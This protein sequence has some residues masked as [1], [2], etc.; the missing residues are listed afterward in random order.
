M[1]TNLSIADRRWFVGLCA[2]IVYTEFTPRCSDRTAIPFCLS[3]AP[4][5]KVI[6]QGDGDYVACLGSPRPPYLLCAPDFGRLVEDYFCHNAV[7]CAC[8]D[9]EV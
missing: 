2:R 3:L 6:S 4:T 7:L 1:C 9:I 8:T 5:V